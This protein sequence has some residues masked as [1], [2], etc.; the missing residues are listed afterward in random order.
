LCVFV[1]VVVGAL[2]TVIPPA[3]ERYLVDK[4]DMARYVILNKP[5]WM[6]QNVYNT[7]LLMMV[8]KL[9]LNHYQG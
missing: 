9:V 6:F 1:V 5:I 7:A 8:V 3:G 2:P 4:R